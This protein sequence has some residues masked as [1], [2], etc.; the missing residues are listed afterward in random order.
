VNELQP[1][2]FF[3]FVLRHHFGVPFFLFFA[4]FLFS[5]FDHSL[6]L[7]VLLVLFLKFLLVPKFVLLFS[8]GLFLFDLL[9]NLS[10]LIHQVLFALLI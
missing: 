2:L 5:F 8:L 4:L 6:L 9:E 7:F 10:M 1:L 3:L